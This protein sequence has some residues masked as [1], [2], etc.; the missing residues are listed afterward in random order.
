MGKHNGNPDLVCA[1]RLLFNFGFFL[2][3]HKTPGFKLYWLTKR[4]PRIGYVKPYK[5]AILVI[6]SKA[7]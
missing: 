5:V 4:M 3:V 2:V 7:C 1:N 6:V